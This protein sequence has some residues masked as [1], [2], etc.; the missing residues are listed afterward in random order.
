M[1]WDT[2]SRRRGGSLL[3]N[4]INLVNILIADLRKKKY[5]YSN[6][7][8]LLSPSY[9]EVYQAQGGGGGTLCPPPEFLYFLANCYEIWY[10]CKTSHDLKDGI[11]EIS[12]GHHMGAQFY[13]MWP[14]KIGNKIEMICHA[15]TESNVWGSNSKIT[16]VNEPK[17]LYFIS[18]MINEDI[19]CLRLAYLL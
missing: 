2:T 13:K 6:D 18:V 8:T 14:K 15:L 9:F 1:R 17:L 3:L 5:M 11:V 4:S 12:L 16:S 19:S 7:L 10:R